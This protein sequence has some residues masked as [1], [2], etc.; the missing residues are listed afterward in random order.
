MRRSKQQT[1]REF[2]RLFHEIPSFC[3]V[4]IFMQA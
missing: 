4:Y 2:A 3:L 1:M